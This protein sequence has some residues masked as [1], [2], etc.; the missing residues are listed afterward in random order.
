MNKT[1]NTNLTIRVAAYCR[2][3]TGHE[4]QN[5]S[6]EAQKKFF[7]EL[8]DKNPEWE[9]V[10]IYA[11]RG[12]SGTSTKK[13]KEFNR[14]INDAVEGNKIDLIVT[15]E[16]SRFAR[17]V[18][19]T[20]SY[21]R[22]LKKD[23]GVYINFVYDNI[24]TANPEDEARLGYMAINAQEESR[25]T[26]TRVNWGMSQKMK[27]GFAMGRRP[28][29][30]NL[31][32]G[33]LAIYDEEAEIVRLIFHKYVY[34][35]KGHLAIAKELVALN[36]PV[37]GY[38][39]KWSEVA[40]SRILVNEKYV[41]DLKSE[42]TFTPDYL[43]HVAVANK[44]ENM[45]YFYEHHEAIISREIWLL[46]QEEHGRRS[47]MSIDNT[48]YSNRYWASGKLRCG[49]C[50]TSCV[51]RNKYNKDGSVIR[52]WYCKEA[53][54][55][56]IKDD[57]SKLEN[58]GCNSSL[59]NDTALLECVH[60]AL[61]SVSVNKELIFKTVSEKLEAVCRISENDN[62]LLQYENKINKAVEKK[63][64]LMDA[65]FEGTIDKVELAQMKE[66][67][68]EE[69]NALSE[70]RERL[71]AESKIVENSKENFSK[72]I[73]KVNAILSLDSHDE[74]LYRNIIDKIVLLSDHN[75]DVHF[76]YLHKP[77]RLH[78]TTTGRKATYKVNCTELAC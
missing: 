69:I 38:I 52:F 13:R 19:D 57:N 17:N 39:K 6:F 40:V 58:W 77:I 44:E 60:F 49:E 75:I 78:F 16:V 32:K 24:N 3:S 63:A 66:R 76:K 68:T 46:A 29:G 9:L 72:L 43:D 47:A 1:N 23:K 55:Y 22:M 67:Y 12:L 53:Y 41:G 64:R 35:G 56:G 48:H 36:I 74:K 70:H 37:G 25:K 45:R 73:E 34:E 15:K 31:E 42:K 7:A 33:V 59:V 18:V 21:A 27:D 30:F 51:S 65:Y 8:I 50:G 20:L 61:E 2:V 26:S 11:D 71:L 28:F 10:D 5:N 62:T 4:E 54:T 14:M